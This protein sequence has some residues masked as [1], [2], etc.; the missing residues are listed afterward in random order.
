MYLLR[1]GSRELWWGF[2]GRPFVGDHYLGPRRVCAPQ[3][4]AGPCGTPRV[5][6]HRTAV[7][8][9]VSL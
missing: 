6:A 8:R 9:C 4:Y 5:W 3:M 1:W 2:G 7:M